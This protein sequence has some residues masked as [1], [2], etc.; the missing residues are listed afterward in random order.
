MPPPSN[1]FNV[2]GSLEQQENKENPTL[3]KDISKDENEPNHPRSQDVLPSTPAT[4]L[5]LADLIGDSEIPKNPIINASPQ[6]QIQWNIVTTP[7]DHKRKKTSA[8][9]TRSKKRARSSSPPSATSAA[10]P[11]DANPLLDLQGLKQSLNTPQANPATNLWTRYSH[12]GMMTSKHGTL[13]PRTGSLPQPASSSH[14]ADDQTGNV[15]GLRRWTSCGTEWPSSKKKRRKMFHPMSLGQ[16]DETFDDIPKSGID[17]HAAKARSDRIKSLLQGVQEGLSRT[18]DA[19]DLFIDDK[20]PSSSSPLPDRIEEFDRSSISPCRPQELPSRAGKVS[21]QEG[22][23][24]NT[25]SEMGSNSNNARQPKSSRFGTD[26]FEDEMSHIALPDVS[27]HTAETV[28]ATKV[29]PEGELKGSTQEEQPPTPIVSKWN[30]RNSSPDK[31]PSDHDG[32]EADD[33]FGDN[34]MFSG[35]DFDIVAS[36]CDHGRT[37]PSASTETNAVSQTPNP[38]AAM[39]ALEEED[40]GDVDIDEESFAAI[41]ASTTQTAASSGESKL[42]VCTL[43]SH[44]SK[45]TY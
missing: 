42:P 40:F 45:Y 34:E 16:I 9:S 15:A 19:D 41:E 5:P 30:I 37:Q 11:K 35:D 7:L 3:P 27:R 20:G 36:M 8:R 12:V 24:Q 22:A 39:N 31:K 43:N 6:E 4:R 10:R 26:S 2:E 13:E 1:S 18:E 38:N 28:T 17:R 14:S 32:D 25:T 44:T 29:S 33:E 21:T 23:Q